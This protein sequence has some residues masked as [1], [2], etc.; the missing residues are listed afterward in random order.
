MVWKTKDDLYGFLECFRPDGAGLEKLFTGVVGGAEI[1]QRLLR[2]FACTKDDCEGGSGYF[3][4][5][6][7]VPATRE[8]LVNLT[9]QHLRNVRRIAQSFGAHLRQTDE[10]D[11]SEHDVGAELATLL[12]KTPEIAVVNEPAP[13]QLEPDHDA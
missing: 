8:R 13:V 4:V 7:P 2:V 5:R 1:L 11:Q 12:E 10:P 3:I 9:T 6:R